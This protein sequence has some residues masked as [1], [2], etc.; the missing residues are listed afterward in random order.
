MLQ[1]ATDSVIAQEQAGSLGSLS[2]SGGKIIPLSHR[3]LLPAPGWSPDGHRLV[4]ITGSGGV[5]STPFEEWS[6]SP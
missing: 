5:L 4:L 3:T 2:R 6:I 1:G